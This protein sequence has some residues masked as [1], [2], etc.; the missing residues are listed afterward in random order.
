MAQTKIQLEFPYSNDWLY[1][2]VNTNSDGRETL[3]LYNSDNDR[4]STQYAR[5]LLAVYLKRYLTADEH[6]DHIDG[7]KNNNNLNNLQILSL[8][9]NNV[10]THKKPDIQ[11]VCPICRK[12]FTRTHTQLR[13]KKHLIDTNTLCCSRSCGSA[14]GHKT[15]LNNRKDNS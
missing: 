11:L 7:D 14:Q 3:T 12:P 2:Y 9:E 15:K 4:S 8:H 5:Y 13:G 10:K 1:G 6:V